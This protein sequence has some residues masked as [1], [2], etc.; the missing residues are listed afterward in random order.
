MPFIQH[1]CASKDKMQYV[2]KEAHKIKSY[3][4]KHGLSFQEA[5]WVKEA[6]RLCKEKKDVD[7]IK[8]AGYTPYSTQAKRREQIISILKQEKEKED[9][10]DY[11]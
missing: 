1:L 4:D 6:I 11:R 5:S 8:K 9:V 3:A 2:S 7:W 10:Q